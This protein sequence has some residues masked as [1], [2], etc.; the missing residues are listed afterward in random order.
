MRNKQ[1]VA[2]TSKLGRFHAEEDATHRL[3][4]EQTETDRQTLADKQTDRQTDR[5]VI[6]LPQRQFIPFLFLSYYWLRG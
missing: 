5:L 6:I 2:H 4:G 1:V 3:T